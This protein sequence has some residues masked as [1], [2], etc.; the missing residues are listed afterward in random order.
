MKPDRFVLPLV[1]QGDYATIDWAVQTNF[2]AAPPVIGCRS[3]EVV[4]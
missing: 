2:T 4:A 3:A 1:A